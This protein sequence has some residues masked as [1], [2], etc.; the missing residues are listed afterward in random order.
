MKDYR[1]KGDIT[2][3]QQELDWVNGKPSCPNTSGECCPDFS[4]CRPNLLW[5]KKMRDKFHT[6]D[7]GTRHKMMMLALSALLE[8]ASKKKVHITRGDPADHG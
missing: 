4:C 8:D 7:Q 1:I 5:E 2:P 3:E 6:A